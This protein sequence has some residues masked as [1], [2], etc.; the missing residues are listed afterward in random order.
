MILMKGVGRLPPIMENS[1]EKTCEHEMEA[2]NTYYIAV[3]CL[4]ILYP[5]TYNQ[6]TCASLICVYGQGIFLLRSTTKE[7][8]PAAVT[9]LKFS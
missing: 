7:S 2:R 6:N 9:E 8:Y 1:T 5:P 4:R 3:L